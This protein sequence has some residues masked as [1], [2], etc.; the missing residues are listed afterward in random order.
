VVDWSFGSIMSHSPLL[1]RLFRPRILFHGLSN[2]ARA[3]NMLLTRLPAHR[4]SLLWPI[5]RITANHILSLLF[6]YRAS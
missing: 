3:M 1:L 4:L 5:L 6:S 2:F